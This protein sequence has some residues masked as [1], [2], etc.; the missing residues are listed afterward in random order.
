MSPN[1][2]PQNNAEVKEHKLIAH[3]ACVEDH[4]G[5][6]F[7]A[8]SKGVTVLAPETSGGSYKINN[9]FESNSYSVK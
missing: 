8:P 6:Y 9:R 4:R 5:F 1:R 3:R 7:P 2:I